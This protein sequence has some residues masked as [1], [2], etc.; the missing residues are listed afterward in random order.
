MIKIMYS[1]TLKIYFYTDNRY[2]FPHGWLMLV[3]GAN[4]INSSRSERE[5]EAGAPAS[6]VVVLPVEGAT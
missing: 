6:R 3:E 4:A 5:G 1:Y 2:G